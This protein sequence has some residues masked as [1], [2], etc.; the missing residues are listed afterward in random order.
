MFDPLVPALRAALQAKVEGVYART[1]RLNADGTYTLAVPGRPNFMYV[2]LNG[3]VANVQQALNLKVQWRPDL[4][5]RVRRTAAGV[6][7][8]V[9][10]H[11]L[12]TSE[13]LGTTAAAM[14][15]PAADGDGVQETVA[16]RSLKPGRLRLAADSG[17]V[18]A[19]E[20]FYY[21]WR[22][23]R[24]FFEGG[25]IDL[26]GYRPT[27]AGT[28]AWVQVYVNPVT[29]ALAAVTGPPVKLRDLLTLD[30][31]AALAVGDGVPVDAVILRQGQTAQPVEA[32]FACGRTL[33]QARDQAYSA[34]NVSVPP[35]AA[36]LTS[37]FGAP[38]DVGA[39]FI[40]VVN[41]DGAGLNVWLAVSDGA[42][43][44]HVA[45]TLAL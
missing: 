39:G 24:R 18:F 16:G 7:E 27:P 13:A 11:G 2:R 41:D 10:V 28:W 21:W 29:N 38:A 25:V 14:N 3:D 32:D 31:L 12:E 4:P 15:R 33:L 37:A 19:V 22:G 6:W 26:A 5:V 43:W 23:R 36:E 17:L 34:A 8:I 20:P 45:C 42:A 44:W 35:T 9:D 1:G 30:A 40:G